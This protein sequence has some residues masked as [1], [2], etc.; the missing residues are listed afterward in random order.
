MC[1]LSLFHSASLFKAKRLIYDVGRPE[2]PTAAP[3]TKEERVV[4]ETK[5]NLDNI[6]KQIDAFKNSKKDKLSKEGVRA[7]DTAV[8]NAQILA[9][10]IGDRGVKMLKSYGTP[11]ES[12]HYRNVVVAQ[13]TTAVEMEKMGQEIT[14]SYLK[15]VKNNSGAESLE[16]LN[17]KPTD[18][19]A[20]LDVLAAGQDKKTN[21]QRA[22]EQVQGLKAISY[23]RI[24]GGI[25]R[26]NLVSLLPLDEVPDAE[27][28]TAFEKSN[29][30]PSLVEGFKKLSKKGKLELMLDNNSLRNNAL[31]LISSL[32]I[33]N[34]KV[35]EKLTKEALWN[36]LPE[37]H[38]LKKS[39]TLEQFKT[40]K[41]KEELI[42][43]VRGEE[44]KLEEKRREIATNAVQNYAE[45]P[46]SYRG[47]IEEYLQKSP[48]D[49]SDKYKETL[50][51]DFMKG[52]IELAAAYATV[53]NL[54]EGTKGLITEDLA[55]KLEEEK[56]VLK[57][58]KNRVEE[59]VQF[60][61]PGI[62]PLFH[63]I[64]MAFET[65]KNASKRFQKVQSLPDYDPAKT[66]AKNWRTAT[67]T[68]R[69]K[70]VQRT[71]ERL[72]KDV[73]QIHKNDALVYEQKD[74]W[75]D[76]AVKDA[77]DSL[78]ILASPS[79]N[80]E[81]NRDENHVTMMKENLEKFGKAMEHVYRQHTYLTVLRA[82]IPSLLKGDK[83][84]QEKL[85][86][87]IDGIL[88]K[89]NDAIPG[90]D[91]KIKDPDFKTME[92]TDDLDHRADNGYRSANQNLQNAY[93]AWEKVKNLPNSTPAVKN[94]KG[95]LMGA[96]QY[97]NKALSGVK[98]KAK[99]N[100][101]TRAGIQSIDL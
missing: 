60:Y 58:L 98:G 90:P 48:K 50:P 37:D 45:I 97:W 42:I 56:T 73:G 64:E 67:A 31:A 35:R 49:N 100:A 13:Q 72:K 24:M 52:V 34:E 4:E 28:D 22:I 6:K 25:S 17:T 8:Q 66:S 32:I 33:K 91:S 12:E 63:D 27:V 86:G 96:I 5:K 101:G 89:I 75:T 23:E 53:E 11:A 65:E 94:A 99:V 2:G 20:V 57:N 7:V 74:I 15:D 29:Q 44:K 62:T 95:W 59:Y 61:S 43:D 46:I 70:A 10:S 38:I 14:E 92:P 78:K 82:R 87:E 81:T 30:N 39:F 55:K 16:K 36:L 77:R 83:A 80:L 54:I 3:K 85:R 68:L 51:E 9:S 26:E 71:T 19:S 69:D 41:T 84:A 79:N 93:L 40:F 88:T 18:F 21:L 76:V 1:N 47:A